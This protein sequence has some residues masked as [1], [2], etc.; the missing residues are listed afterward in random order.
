[1]TE[2][3]PGMVAPELRWGV[4]DVCSVQLRLG[5]SANRP[6]LLAVDTRGGGASFG[7]QQGFFSPEEANDAYDITEWLAVQPWSTGAIGMFGRSYL[8]ITQY[9][10]ASK[11][12][13]HL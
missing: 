11:A 2:N 4:A 1:M 12:P 8:G 5:I 10:A 13:P 7:T 3:L 6:R 9:F